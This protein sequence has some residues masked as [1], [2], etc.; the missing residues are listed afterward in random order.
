MYNNNQFDV[1]SVTTVLEGQDSVP[2]HVKLSIELELKIP[3]VL[4]DTH[5]SDRP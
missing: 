1:I 5:P 2:V 4:H 3:R